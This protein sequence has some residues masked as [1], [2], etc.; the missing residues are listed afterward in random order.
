M[1][2]FLKMDK[3]NQSKINQ[4]WT[5]NRSKIARNGGLEASWRRLGASWVVLEAFWGVLGGLEPS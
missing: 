2:H 3:Q 5:N 4:K 1:K